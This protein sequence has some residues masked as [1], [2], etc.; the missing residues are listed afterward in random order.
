MLGSAVALAGV[1]LLFVQ[2]MRVTPT[3]PP[4]TVLIGIGFTLLGGAGR[5]GRPTSCSRPSGEAA[6]PIAS[7]LAWAM[8]YGALANALIAWALHGPPVV[9]TAARLLARPRL[10]RPGRLGARLLLLFPDH[11]R[12][13][14]RPRRPIRACS[15]RSSRW[16]FSTIFEIIAGRRSPSPAALLALAGLVIALT[17]RGRLRPT[18]APAFAGGLG[19][20]LHHVRAPRL[21]PRHARRPERSRRA[22]AAIRRE[23]YRPPDWLVPGDRAGIRARRRADAGAR[24]LDGRAQRRPR[25]AAAARRRGAASCVERHG[26]RRAAA[27]QDLRRRGPDHRSEPASR[28]SSRPRSRSRP[29]ANTQLMGL[30]ESG[31]MLCTQC[32]AEGFRRITPFPDRPDVLSRYRVRMIADKAAY[33][34]LLSNGDP[35]GARRSRRRPPLGRVARSLPQALLSVRAGRRRPRRQSRQLRHPLRPQGRARHLGARGGPAA[36]RACDE[37]AQG[38]DE[39][40]RGGLRP[41]I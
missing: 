16:C 8:L 35:V 24:A 11:P 41:R 38:G 33:P 13:R 5:L 12:G 15:C 28:A 2:E 29:R 39:V 34:V 19:I 32:E 22:A 7:M 17:G 30:Y 18:P 4:A 20:A 21:N 6:W 14:R 26:R 9:E 36:H 3:P 31:G 1:A 10:S 27:E 40:G 23:D 37:R 25:T